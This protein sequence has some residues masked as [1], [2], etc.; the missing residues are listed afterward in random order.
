MEH[1]SY[2]PTTKPIISPWF[3]IESLTSLGGLMND[4]PRAIDQWHSAL[5]SY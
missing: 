4:A 2:F 1:V 5:T 3:L